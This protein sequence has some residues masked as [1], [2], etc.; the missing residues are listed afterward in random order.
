MTHNPEQPLL[1]IAQ[2]A[3]QSVL[4]QLQQE[5]PK[6]SF[7]TWV[8]DTEVFSYE[9]DLMTIG[10]RNAY[11]CDWLESR[12]TGTVE[13]MLAE[14]L[15]REMAVQFEALHAEYAAEIEEDTPV[16]EEPKT[17]EVN[18][19]GWEDTYQEIARPE[20]AVYL[21]GYFRRWLPALGPELGWL[22]VAFR[23]A[24]YLSGG[25]SGKRSGRFSGKQVAALCGIS[26]RTFWNRAGKDETWL[27]L[28]GLVKRETSAPEWA[29]ESAVPRRLPVRYAVAMTL[30]L[31]PADTCSLR[32]WLTDHLGEQT[33]PEIL[34]RAAADAPLEELLISHPASS[35]CEAM[36]V[37]QVVREIFS[38][39]LPQEKLDALASVLQSHIM[40]SKDLIVIPLFFLEHIL[41]HLG[42]GPGW[43]LTLLRDRCWVDPDTGEARTRL[44]VQGGYAEIAG[45]LGLQRPKTVWE[46]FH[47]RYGKDHQEAGSLKF[48]LTRIFIR[49]LEGE[50]RAVECFSTASRS[51]EVLL[52]DIPAEIL[53]AS[54][55]GSEVDSGASCSIGMARLSDDNGASFSIAV[56]RF[57]EDV[58]ASCRVFK[59]LNS[60][61]PTPITPD[62]PPPLP[63]SREKAEK[64]V[65]GSQAFWDF[66]FLM[67]NNAVSPGGIRVLL[68]RK[69]KFSEDIQQI[70]TGFVSWLL[71]AYSPAGV[72]INDPVGLAVKRMQENVHPG[73]GG[74][75]DRLARLRPYEL[76]QFFDLD[77]AGRFETDGSIER[78]IYGVT[79]GRLRREP[80]QELYRRLF[81]GME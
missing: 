72:R 55:S 33:D 40:P 50:Q 70:A 71:Y 77:L 65:V 7:D 32:Q 22:Y 1:A 45:W 64:P 39:Q 36:T 3:W 78:D 35:D 17:I 68:S 41:P 56:A 54:L 38:D 10:V 9:K 81:G 30:P 51:F 8:R 79:F 63:P 59:A 69:K 44:T 52:E 23:K 27:K 67:R 37:R 28:S 13:T 58:G 19:S 57:S 80:K 61:K 62:S 18:A 25:R 75:L 14:F 46:W 6:A 48:P 31:T 12:L 73:V 11:A 24:A 53:A 42:S 16:D 47:G 74:D 15:N 29:E 5:M 20:R 49:E 21:P 2:E 66:D 76:R 34:L 43:M 26:E 60:L 4:A